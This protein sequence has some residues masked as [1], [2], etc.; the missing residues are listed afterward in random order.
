[1]PEPSFEI[2]ITFKATCALKEVN[3][4]QRDIA[5][6]VTALLDCLEA[7]RPYHFDPTS[8]ALK[9]SYLYQ[10]KES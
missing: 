10:R 8:L 9:A 2:H 5:D 6:Q 7:N 3:H 4:L 1:M